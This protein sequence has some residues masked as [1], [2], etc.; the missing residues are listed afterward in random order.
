MRLRNKIRSGVGL[1]RRKTGRAR[2]DSNHLFGPTPR[3]CRVVTRVFEIGAGKS[4]LLPNMIRRDL[5]QWP[6][7]VTHCGFPNQ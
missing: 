6:E 1:W 2:G 5:Y 3:L 7:T 4:T